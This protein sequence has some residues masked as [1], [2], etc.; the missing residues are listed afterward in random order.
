MA[1]DYHA[2]K[3][4]ETPE[5]E[6]PKYPINSCDDVED[7]WLLRN[8][9]DYSISTETLENRIQERARKL[10]CDVPGTEEEG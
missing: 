7:A 9:G 4:S 2:V 10:G 5:G 3:E 1:Q 8:H 6:G